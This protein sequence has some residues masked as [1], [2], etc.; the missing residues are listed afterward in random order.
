MQRCS[1]RQVPIGVPLESK[2]LGVFV[3]CSTFSRPLRRCVPVA[4][5]SDQREKFS[6]EF[7]VPMPNRPTPSSTPSR[8]P[9]AGRIDAAVDKFPA[10]IRKLE[11]FERSGRSLEE[12]GADDVSE[13]CYD[14]DTELFGPGLPRFR[15]QTSTSG[16]G[17]GPPYVN[18]DQR[19][20]GLATE[21]GSRHFITT[22]GTDL[23]ARKERPDFCTGAARPVHGRAPLGRRV[24]ALSVSQL[25]EVSL[26]GGVV[27]TTV[28]G[29]TYSLGRTVSPK[30]PGLLRFNRSGRP[31]GPR[32]HEGMN[33][34]SSRSG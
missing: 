29:T 5:A 26:G 19:L 6:R 16:S 7:L 21:R 30:T 15:E 3:V 22:L 24:A 18:M 17:P 13:Q 14:D 1:F 9:L 23:A 33:A 12:T 20:Y 10:Q 2:K 28:D 8:V 31:N 25:R 34:I 27:A 4:L 32:Q 11:N